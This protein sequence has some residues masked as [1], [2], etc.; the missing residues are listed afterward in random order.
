[1]HYDSTLWY[2]R[3]HS[4]FTSMYL[5][6]CKMDWSAERK[7]LILTTLG[8]PWCW[9]E[10]SKVF[11]QVWCRLPMC[12]IRSSVCWIFGHNQSMGNWVYQR[13]TVIRLITLLD[14]TDHLHSAKFIH[15]CRPIFIIMCKL[16]IFAI[17]FLTYVYLF[18]KY[19][20][21]KREVNSLLDKFNDIYQQQTRRL[22]FKVT[23][24]QMLH[25]A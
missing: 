4:S 20:C 7:K 9:I 24:L 13:V 21:S 3:G 23:R 19:I 18:T 5:Y 8:Q 12:I 6:I 14:S 22:I 11:P 25:L 16:L 2:I 15:T 1:M 17:W 10:V